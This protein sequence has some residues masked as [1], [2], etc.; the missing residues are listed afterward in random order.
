VLR[1]EIRELAGD[2]LMLAGAAGLFT[3][4]FLIWSHQFSPGFLAQ[5]AGSRVLRGVPRDPTAWQVYSV[6]D[7]ALALLA[8]ALVL[9]ALR[10][11]RGVRQAVLVAAAIALA[12]TAHALAVPPTN[13]AYIAGGVSD[14]PSAGVGETVAIAALGAAIA[15]LGLSFT[16]PPP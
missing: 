10:G 14:S 2:L 3:S 9:T 13:G 6:A 8:V 15:G 11:G 1:R 16:V 7:V 12:F 4:L 5:W